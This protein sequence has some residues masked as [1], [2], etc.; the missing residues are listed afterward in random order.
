MKRRKLVQVQIKALIDLKQYL[1]PFKL[2]PTLAL[3]ATAPRSEAQ[4]L[5]LEVSEATNHGVMWIP[6]DDV[7]C[8]E[9]AVLTGPMQIQWMGQLMKLRLQFVFHID[10]K[11]KLH[12]AGS[13]LNDLN[14]LID[15]IFPS[16]MS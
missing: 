10:S 15:D 8:V 7:Y 5:A 4:V 1:L 2:P 6:M 11:F 9:G 14:G 16:I 12:H 3:V 13:T